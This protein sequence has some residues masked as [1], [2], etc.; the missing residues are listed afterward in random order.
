MMTVLIKNN[1]ISMCWLIALVNV[2]FAGGALS[3][4]GLTAEDYVTVKNG[5]L[6]RHGKRIRFWAANI[7]T[8]ELNYPRTAG[9]GPGY[10]RI[11]HGIKRLKKLGFNAV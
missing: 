7:Y 3:A 4:Q 11:D 1:R 8:L 9:S 6:S 10:A 2:W 5:H